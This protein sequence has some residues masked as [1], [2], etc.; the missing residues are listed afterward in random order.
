MIEAEYGSGRLALELIQASAVFVLVMIAVVVWERTGYAIGQWRQRRLERR[1]QSLIQRALGGDDDAVRA[2]A[3]SPAR[4][5]LALLVQLI[6]PLIENRDP[7]RIART[8]VITQGLAFFS[9]A[10]RYLRSVW[11]WRRAIALRAFGLMQIRE[12]TGAIV[13]ALDDTHPA[14]RA[15]SLDALTDLQDPASMQ[16]IVVRMHDA[17]LQRGRRAAAL[18]AF[19]QQSEEF[20]LELAAIDPAH[21]LNYARALAVGGSARARPVL[22][23][24]TADDRLPVRAAAF[25]ALA[26]V[27]LDD[28]A[29]GVALEG[30]NSPDVSVRAMAARALHG[31]TGDAVTARLTSRLDDAWP[32]AVQAARSLRSIGPSGLAALRATSARVDLAGQLARQM[33]W[34]RERA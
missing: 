9:V 17:T 22:C 15:A 23:Q 26:R 12:R 11:W 13:A 19:G 27:G 20:V 4:H 18:G 34:E 21:R 29:V 14:V 1:Y 24:W 7:G 16:A 30:L 28:E 10:D 25:E 2:L 31:S 32:V 6:T 5:R 8:R 33:L 3:A